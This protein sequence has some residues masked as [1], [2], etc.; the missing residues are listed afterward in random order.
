MVM[1]FEEATDSK[2]DSGL[3][4]FRFN[5]QPHYWSFLTLVSF[6]T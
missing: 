4:L 2:F 1:P 5:F 3:P 6:K